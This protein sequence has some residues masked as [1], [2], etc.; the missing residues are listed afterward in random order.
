MT[1]FKFWGWFNPLSEHVVKDKD[2]ILELLTEL[3]WVQ[4]FGSKNRGSFI[5]NE[6]LVPILRH[7]SSSVSN[8]TKFQDFYTQKE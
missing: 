5:L 3:E 4:W 2:R 7:F 1:E 8:D 6:R